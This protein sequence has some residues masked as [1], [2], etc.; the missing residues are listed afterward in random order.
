MEELEYG[1]VVTEETIV[2]GATTKH[3]VKYSISRMVD[4][5]SQALSE[6]MKALDLVSSKQ[7]HNVTISV[8]ADPRTHNFKRIVR[9]H[10]VERKL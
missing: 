9:T 8:E 10:L 2:A 6:I 5:R 3:E 1:K 7:T 4:G